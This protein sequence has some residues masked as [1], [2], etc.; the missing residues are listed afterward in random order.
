MI[1]ENEGAQGHT[2][3]REAPADGLHLPTPNPQFSQI[4]FYMAVWSSALQRLL[5]LPAARTPH[6]QCPRPSPSTEGAEGSGLVTG[7]PPGHR[8][9]PRPPPAPLRYRHPNSLAACWGSDR[10][11][12]AARPPGPRGRVLGLSWPP[13]RS[14]HLHGCPG[15]RLPAPSTTDPRRGRPC[16]APPW[17][18]LSSEAAVSLRRGNR[19]PRPARPTR[20]AGS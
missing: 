7:A 11:S 6:R 14:P 2:G 9:A 1:S 10:R 8:V 5:P 18:L 16:P 19:R 20:L 12:A 3:A 4:N 17:R 13:C 15:R